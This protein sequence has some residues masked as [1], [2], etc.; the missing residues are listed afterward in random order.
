MQFVCEQQ[1]G[2]LDVVVSAAVAELSRSRA[3]ALIRQG[4]V[5]VDGVVCTKASTKLGVGAVIAVEIPEP[6]PLDVLPEN[7]PLDIVYEDADLMVINKA[8]GMVVHPSPGH[9]SGT[10]VNAVLHHAD[11]L[12]G[13]GGVAR[14][15]IVHRL[16]KGTS[17]LIAVAKS[18]RAHQG[19]SAQFADHSAQR[20][21]VAICLGVPVLTSGTIRNEL[22]RDP[23]DRLRYASV[24]EGGKSAC[25]HWRVLGRGD[26]VSLIQCRLETGR[27]HQIRVH[28]TEKGWPIAGDP[29]YKRRAAQPT[30]SL[31]PH[32]RP[33]RPML[34]AWELR[35][36]HPGSG[37]PMTFVGQ[38]PQDFRAAASAVSLVEHLPLGA[39]GGEIEPG[40]P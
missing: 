36:A 5:T 34:H 3:T 25:T 26:R 8:A 13:I 7:I 28:L 17:G 22:G 2:R 19:L 40:V 6:V 12:S 32:L 4:M 1:R 39:L 29:L 24:L 30:V 15:G 11:K 31:R 14:P 21:Y 35:F 38:V 10:L 18:D 9:S 33:N 27:T 16:D 37:E 23:R 20:A